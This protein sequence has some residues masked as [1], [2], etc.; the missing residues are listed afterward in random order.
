VTVSESEPTI[1]DVLAV[2]RELAV[3]TD[4]GFERV[5]TDVAQLNEGQAHMRADGAQ[6][7]EGQA[8][9]RAD[10]SQVRADIAGLKT[11]AAFQE[12]FEHDTAEA[13]RHHLEHHNPPAA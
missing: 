9:I 13:L 6:L 3:R 2:L 8:Q 11:Q 4:Q 10:I 12:R 5:R 7:R 1:A